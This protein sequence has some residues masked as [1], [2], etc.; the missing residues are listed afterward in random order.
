MNS[1][2]EAVAAKAMGGTG[3][4]VDFQ[5]VV[6]YR[7]ERSALCPPDQRRLPAYRPTGTLWEGGYREQPK[8]DLDGRRQ[9]GLL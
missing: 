4:R 2:R 1:S 8:D 9:I 3:T 7:G 6:H 5:R